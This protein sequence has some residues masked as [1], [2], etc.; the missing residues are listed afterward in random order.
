MSPSTADAVTAAGSALSK[1]NKTQNQNAQFILKASQQTVVPFSLFR[2]KVKKL[3]NKLSFLSKQKI[4]KDLC[5][6][7]FFFDDLLFFKRLL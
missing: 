4:R 5:Y 3:R 6:I 2:D 7:L 1:K